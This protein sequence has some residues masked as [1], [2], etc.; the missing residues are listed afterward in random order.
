MSETIPVLDLQGYE[1]LHDLEHGLTWNPVSLS[2]SLVAW[3]GLLAAGACGFAMVLGFCQGFDGISA[4]YA[5][6]WAAA[7]GAVVSGMAVG[8]E[9]AYT[10]YR[11]ARLPCPGCGRILG[12]Y[13]ADLEE[14]ERSRWRGIR[15]RCLDGRVYSAPFL[16]ND[17]DIRP[18]VRVMKEVRACPS[19][20]GYVDCREPHER[21]CSGEELERLEEQHTRSI[22]GDRD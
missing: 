6:G 4:A 9:H 15:Q 7:G 18:W 1:R 16:G 5:W 22:Q 10:R 2:L 14:A 13:V 17:E 12:Q 21:T 3:G 19:C 20:R 8:L 11:L